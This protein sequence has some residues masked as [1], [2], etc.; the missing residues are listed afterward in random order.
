MHDGDSNQADI[1]PP[2]SDVVEPEQGAIPA[3]D[4]ATAA[5]ATFPG[6]QPGA[7]VEAPI[8]SHE[9]GGLPSADIVGPETAG[10]EAPV[11]ELADTTNEGGIDPGHP[12]TDDV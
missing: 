11:G 9:S 5:A 8:G 6:T 10:D 12:K 3:R 7:A 4:E 1:A 2:E